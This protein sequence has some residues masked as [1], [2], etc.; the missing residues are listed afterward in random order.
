MADQEEMT[1]EEQK[2][3]RQ[4]EETRSALSEKLE[5]L[6]NQVVQTVQDATC[7]VSET[8]DNVK[9]AVQE[10]VQSVKGT[11]ENT[12]E[13]VRST[14]DLQR[15]MDEHPWACVGSAAAAGFI[16]AYLFGGG[17]SKAERTAPRERR[18][19][20]PRTGEERRPASAAPSGIGSLF[21]DEFNKV[22]GIA[23]G[24]LFGLVRDL[25]TEM[26]PQQLES[27]VTDLINRVTVKLGGEPVEGHLI[28]H[29]GNGR[30]GGPGMGH[31][32]SKGTEGTCRS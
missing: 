20:W 13:S 5:T 25:V 24:T 22:R 17:Q 16:S 26:V 15:H 4:M 19:S 11:V 28:H 31:Q 21:G 27:Q 6:E 1:G 30:H 29:T 23:L 3:R 14:F 18:E 7:A 8:V 2:I 12:V 10:T 32:V 9:E